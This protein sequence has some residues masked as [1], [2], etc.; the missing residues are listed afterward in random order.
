MEK[1]EVRRSKREPEPPSSTKLPDWRKDEEEE[2]EIEKNP[3]IWSECTMEKSEAR[4]SKRKL[5]R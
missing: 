4:R 2:E 5:D 1:S 3:K